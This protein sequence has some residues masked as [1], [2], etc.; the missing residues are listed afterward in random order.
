MKITELPRGA[1]FLDKG[2]SGYVYRKAT[3]QPESS[4]RVSV[5]NLMTG[6]QFN[7]SDDSEVIPV[8]IMLIKKDDY[9]KLSR[10]LQDAKDKLSGADIFAGAIGGRLA[11]RDRKI[12]DMKQNIQ[13]MNTCYKTK[14]SNWQQTVQDKLGQIASLTS[15]RDHYQAEADRYDKWCNELQ[16]KCDAIRNMLNATTV[17]RDLYKAEAD[18]YIRLFEERGQVCRDKAELQKKL[19]DL[20]KQYDDLK[21]LCAKTDKD[22][23]AYKYSYYQCQTIHCQ[24]AREWQ[25]EQERLRS[26]AEEL[27]QRLVALANSLDR[28][29]G[30][31]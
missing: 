11:E 21:K 19:D 1:T 7:V 15:E 4:T 18:R 9:D 10:E 17:D 25:Q 31:V 28:L 24:S 5:T 30:K 29:H 16:M 8:E 14:L 12:A 23:A 22:L 26:Q 13:F 20:Q 6:T 3:S 2:E 27:N